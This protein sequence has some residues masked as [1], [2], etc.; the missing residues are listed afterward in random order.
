MRLCVLQ[1]DKTRC[2]I[3]SSSDE[4]NITGILMATPPESDAVRL[5]VNLAPDERKTDGLHKPICPKQSTPMW[6]A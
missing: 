5:M 3:E 4:S 1:M 2:K 6:S